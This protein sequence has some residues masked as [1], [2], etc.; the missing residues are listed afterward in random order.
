MFLNLDFFKNLE[1]S[2]RESSYPVIKSRD[3]LF[4]GLT[5]EKLNSEPDDF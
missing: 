1:S 2:E 5:L 4:L 3:D